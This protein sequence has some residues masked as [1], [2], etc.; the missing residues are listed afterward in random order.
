[1]IGISIAVTRE[2]EAVLKY[3]NMELS[4]CEK[5]PFGEYFCV[6][7]NGK[8]I[9]FYHCGSRKVNSAA[10]SQYMICKY[11]LSKVIVM[12]TCAGIDRKYKNLDIIIPN[13]AVQYDCTVKEIEPLIKQSFTVSI[14]LS[15][16]NL[17]YNTGTIGT[18]DKAVVMWS[19][20]LNLKNNDITVA[21]TESAGVAWVCNKNNIKCLIVKGISDFPKN[22]DYLKEKNGNEEQINEF[23]ENV[24]KV[25]NIILDNYFDKLI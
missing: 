15:D 11:N 17:D 20:Y 21:D 1:M 19:D 23:M 6:V 3:F 8:K 22:A 24:P 5:Y 9:I 10:A 13:K 4:E 2:W 25:M 7:K 18:A 16:L 12:G 14:D